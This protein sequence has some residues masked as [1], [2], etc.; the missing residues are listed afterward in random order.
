MKK[1]SVAAFAAGT[2][3]LLTLLTAAPAFAVTNSGH[4]NCTGTPYTPRITI[5]AK[6]SI[7]GSWVNYVTPSQGST[8]IGP[9]GF[10]QRY[11][12]YINVN[13]AVAASL[14]FYSTTTGTCA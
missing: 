6:S 14:G 8:Y 13:W 3:V 5:N 4:T 1:R 12:P 2:S 9:A 10:S 11:S 7:N